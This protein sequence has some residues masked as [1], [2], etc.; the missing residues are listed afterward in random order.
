[1]KQYET[2]EP[3]GDLPPGEIYTPTEHEVDL[4][5]EGKIHRYMLTCAQNNTA[6]HAPLW[7]NLKALAK[8]YDAELLVSRFTYKISGFNDSVRSEDKRSEPEI[9]QWPKEVVGHDCSHNL[10]LA[11]DLIFAGSI[12]T[13]PTAVN[14]L[15]GLDSYSRHGS[16]IYPHVKVALKSL[17]RFKGDN[18][19]LAMTTGTVTLRNYVQ[20]KTGQVASF[21][22][23]YGCLLVEVDHKGD[24]WA[25]HV[26]SNDS[27]TVRDLDLIVNKGQVFRAKRLGALVWGDIHFDNVSAEALKATRNLVDLLNPQSH[28]IHDLLCFQSRNH[29][30]QKSFGK[31]FYKW[32]TGC[33]NVS[34]EIAR[35]VMFMKQLDGWQ[36]SPKEIA[37]VESNHDRALDRWLEESDFRT[38]P[39]NAEIFLEL[40]LKKLL[41]IK[42]K[43]KWNCL[44]AATEKHPV[45]NCVTFIGEDES[46][47][48]LGIECGLHGDRGANGS[49]GSARGFAA[50]GSKSCIGHS[51]SP[52]IFDG[53]YQAGT[54]T[55]M[56]LGY[57]KGPSS[58]ANAHILLYKSRQ[59]DVL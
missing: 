14:P 22:H 11:P 45:P 13:L 28:V 7:T 41:T 44:Q 47:K 33:E 24:W 8:Y 51:H 39:V 25:R 52:A 12:N 20:K 53:V 19:R 37:V 42:E 59:R 35:T 4:P 31:N 54:T 26:L 9:D 5:P 58:W 1:M 43:R 6:L 48:I 3:D 21:H 57:N 32:L 16:G 40:Q 55:K 50:L 56:L 17:P 38:D 46:Y 49:R 23:S 30:D 2:E 36:K 27:G 29:H 34:G 18:P 15:A 10:R